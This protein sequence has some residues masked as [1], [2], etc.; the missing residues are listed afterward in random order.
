MPIQYVAG[1][2]TQPQGDGPKVIVHC[3]NDQGAWGKGFVLALSQRWP[4]PERQYRAWSAG[5]RAQPFAL[6]E[7]QF[8][9]VTS[10]LWVANLIGQHGIRRQ[11]GQPPIRY[12]AL[13]AGFQRV[14]SF[15]REHGASAHMPRLGA[16]LA[17][18]DWTIIS[19]LLEE[20]LIDRGIP[21]T[22]YDL[23]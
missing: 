11:G 4:E 2:A 23:P 7:V 19:Q 20:E 10:D 5:G 1:D 22:V 13:R 15:A 6:G 8:V 14:A 16:G 21:V 3:C 9:P 17:G 12:E 18:G